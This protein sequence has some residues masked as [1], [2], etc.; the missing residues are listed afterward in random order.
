MD[1]CCDFIA[2]FWN[3]QAAGTGPETF[4]VTV[5][6]A[7]TIERQGTTLEP[8]EGITRQRLEI[9]TAL[10]WPAEADSISE[11]CHG[12]TEDEAAN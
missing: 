8:R 3:V 2:G 7:S 1:T 4:D 5:M 9:K 10:C 11:H 12:P 6:Q